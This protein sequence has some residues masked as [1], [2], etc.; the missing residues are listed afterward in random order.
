MDQQLS[1]GTLT[2]TG[3]TNQRGFLSGSRCKGDIMENFIHYHHGFPVRAR[4]R[5]GIAKGNMIVSDCIVFAMEA[6]RCLLKLRRI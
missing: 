4:L 6:V 5:L 3:F 2:G 1:K